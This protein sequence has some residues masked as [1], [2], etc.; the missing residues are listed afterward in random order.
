MNLSLN[1]Y[2][3]LVKTELANNMGRSYTM[4]E[5]YMQVFKEARLQQNTDKGTF[6]IELSE[7]SG[8]S[9]FRLMK[10]TDEVYKMTKNP[11]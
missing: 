6:D 10:Q 4:F 8:N 2:P 7:G 3:D 5:T 11:S 9:L 1:T